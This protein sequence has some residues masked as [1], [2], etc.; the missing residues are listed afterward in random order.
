MH[1]SS[2]LPDERDRA[3]AR[4]DLERTLAQLHGKPLADADAAELVASYAEYAVDRA[5]VPSLHALQAEDDARRYDVDDDARIRTRDGATISAVVFRPKHVTGRQPAALFFSIYTDGFDRQAAISAAHGY[6]GVT[7]YARGK[8]ASTA[9]IEPYEREV[10]DTYDTIDW[11]SKQPWSDGRVAMYGGSYCG[12]SQWAATKHMHPALKTIV[13]YVAAIPGQGLPMENNIFM[14]ANYGWAFYVTDGPYDDNKVYDDPQRWRALQTTWFR[15]GRPF[16]EIDQVDG[17]PNPWLQRWLQHPAYD[18]YWQSKVPYGADFAK[19][20]IPVL[21]VT[22]YYDDGQISALRYTLE[23]T[24]INKHAQ[25]YVVIGPYDHFGAQYHSPARLRGYTLDPVAVIDTQALTFQWFDHVLRGAPMPELIKDRVNYEVMGANEWRHAPSLDRLD[26]ET[27]TL[28]LADHQL[29]EK[30]PAKPSSIEE[31]VDLANR[32]VQTNSYYPY[33]IIQDPKDFDPAGG[34]VF[35]SAPLERPL[36]VDGML[37]GELHVTINKRDF[38]AGVELYEHRADGTY[39]ALSYYLGRASYARDLTTRHL[40]TPGKPETIPFERARMTSKLLA[41]GSRLV[42][43]VNVNKN[44]F[45]EVNMGTGKTVAD[46]SVKD[47]GE[48]LHVQWSSD[49][50]VKL[51]V[52]R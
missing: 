9:K 33:P 46:E 43:V 22:G 25:H 52:R 29:T 26:N 23:H 36:S 2:F 16:R 21:T 38:D 41:A 19:I 39:F 17:A 50:F 18:A 8:R 45:S 40:L 31:I 1:A 4:G 11:I 7:A 24:R 27:M 14:T 28:Y 44:A 12:Y 47:A 35:E 51:Q 20:D 42:V 15:S 49:S 32:T 30:K 13:P 48:P 6:I 3:R 10:D 34:V 5:L 37:H